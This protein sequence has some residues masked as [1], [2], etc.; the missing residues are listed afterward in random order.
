MKR[1][2]VVTRH[3]DATPEVVWGVLADVARWPEW[4]PTITSV[5]RLDDGPLRLG[6]RARVHQPRL[7]PAEWEVTALEDGRSFTW[8]ANAP[9]VAT[10][11]SHRAEPDATGTAVTLGIEQTG[12]LGLVA[13]VVWGRLT[14]RYI[15]TEAASLEARV[16]GTPTP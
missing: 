15:E 14:Q 6:S 9:G 8:V 2:F 16:T 3:I 10:V 12:P 4:T 5:E 1:V 7:R 13:A 11:G